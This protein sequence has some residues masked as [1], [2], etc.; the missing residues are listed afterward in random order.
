MEIV[1]LMMKDFY[2]HA[3]LNITGDEFSKIIIQFIDKIDKFDKIE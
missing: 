2:E 1:R 3:P